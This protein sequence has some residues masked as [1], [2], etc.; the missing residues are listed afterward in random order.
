MPTETNPGIF[1]YI[2]KLKITQP[3]CTPTLELGNNSVCKK[4]PV[5]KKYYAM[6][7]VKTKKAEHAH[8]E[9][10]RR[11]SKK[12]IEEGILGEPY[13][14]DS[15]SL[16]IELSNLPPSSTNLMSNSIYL[17]TL[18]GFIDNIYH[19][20]GTIVFYNHDGLLVPYSFIL[21][22]VLGNARWPQN[23]PP[24]YRKFHDEWF[25]DENKTALLVSSIMEEVAETRVSVRSVLT[26]LIKRSCSIEDVE[27]EMKVMPNILTFPDMIYDDLIKLLGEISVEQLFQCSKCKRFSID[28]RS[29]RSGAKNRFCSTPCRKSFHNARR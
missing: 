13:R 21:S 14:P 22:D 8:N 27:A 19:E 17:K 10:K 24:G 7:K 18:L 3:E 6:K 29:R 25:K 28:V 2:R 4:C 26:R 5:G 12:K 16:C 15:T 1:C 23:M 9:R 11:E 20:H